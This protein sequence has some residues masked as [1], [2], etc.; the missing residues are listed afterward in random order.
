LEI[1]K[2]SNGK[3]DLSIFQW[4]KNPDTG[5]YEAVPLNITP[6]D[7]WDRWVTYKDSPFEQWRKWEEEYTYYNEDV[8]DAIDMLVDDMDSYPDARMI[9]NYVRNNLGEDDEN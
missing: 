5:E 2:L 8:L 9:I 4:K 7:F 6:D 3:K 1:T